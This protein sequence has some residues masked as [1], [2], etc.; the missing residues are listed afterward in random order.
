MRRLLLFVLLLGSLTMLVAAC[1]QGAQPATEQEE[2]EPQTIEVTR[3]VV[4]TEIVEGES[5]VITETITEEIIVTATPPEVVVE[6]AT[7]VICMAQEPNTLLWSE[8]ALVTSAVLEAVQETVID[9][10][11][12]GYQANLVEK[13][14]AYDDGDATLESVTL[15]E[16]DR[17]YDAATDSVLTLTAGM[18]ESFTLNQV[19][20]DPVVVEGWDGSELT[21]AQQ[22]ADFVLV[23]GLAW[24]DGEPVTADDSVFGWEL[25]TDAN[26]PG[27]QKYIADR[28]AAYEAVDER[29]IRWTG[30]P[31]YVDSTFFLN[32]FQPYPRHVYEGQDWL[33]ITE[34]E[35]ANRD[36]L[37]YGPYA[38]DEWVAGESI[39]LSPNPN[40]F[41]GEPPLA[42]LI[43]RFVPDTNQL[44]AQLASGECDMGTQDAAFEGS[45]PLVRGFEE[46]GL[47]EVVEAIGTT[48]E[49]V[50][51]NMMPV[52]GYTGASAT[53]T[54][55]AG[56]LLFQ[57]VDFR[58][59]I[60]HCMDRQAIVDQA[61]NGGGFVQHSY[62]PI[63]H[64]LYPGDDAITVYEFDPEAG[65]ALLAGLGWEDTDGDGILDKE[66]QTLSFIHS[67]R[68]NPLRQAVTQIVQAQLL[69]N[70][71]IQTEIE[72]VGSEF[73]SDGPEGPVFGRKY[74]LGEFAWLT[75]VE[76]PCNLYIT[77]Q[78]PNEE[79][80][81]GASNNTG[82]SNPEF[83][84]ACTGAL[85][86]TTDEEKA[87]Q[88]AT[89]LG[90]FTDQLPSLPLFARA[91][92]SVVRPGV[93]GV[94][95]D[96]TINSEMWNVENFN[97]TTPTE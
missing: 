6:P 66:G 5:Q 57:N 13:L 37:S 15:A 25:A 91:K 80:G 82:W 76:P 45:L 19:E 44:I 40:Y 87:A 20:G 64:P 70:C 39:T 43:Y 61:T 81:W 96:P 18:T 35:A 12:Y 2:Q 62:V 38:V 28:T 17:I 53:L 92:I 59:A 58:R 41:R 3:E 8:S 16:G 73:F 78:I 72:L 55:N 89:A 36:P 77:S 97:V 95:M 54:D 1:N 46:Q 47:M 56:G 51:F 21:A 24:E 84:A 30:M 14:P 69:E 32:V 34:D 63:D 11:E 50:D 85:Q 26:F 27:Q 74:D 10:P 42:Q 4:V 83:D 33:T 90:I 65:R 88:H 29:T 9:T 60:A 7:M 71:G 48:Y 67:T 52:E 75:G 86:A 93:E 79:N 68:T 23:E 94:I 31:G 49:H 22:T